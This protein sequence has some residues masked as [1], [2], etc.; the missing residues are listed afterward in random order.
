MIKLDNLDEIVRF[1]H[2]ITDNG[3][4]LKELNYYS[5]FDG[6]LQKYLDKLLNSQILKSSP[7]KAH[8][9]LNHNTSSEESVFKCLNSASSKSLKHKKHSDPPSPSPS[10]FLNSSHPKQKSAKKTEMHSKLKKSLIKTEEFSPFVSKSSSRSD[11]TQR[12]T[13]KE[14]NNEKSG[15]GR[16]E[17]NRDSE[18]QRSRERERESLWPILDRSYDEEKIILEGS[19]SREAS[20][21][22]DYK[23]KNQF[24]Q[25]RNKNRTINHQEFH[26]NMAENVQMNNI[27]LNSNLQHKKQGTPVFTAKPEDDQ[28][29]PNTSISRTS[30]VLG[31]FLFKLFNLHHYLIGQFSPAPSTDPKGTKTITTHQLPCQSNAMVIFN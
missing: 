17:R 11:S 21:N 22:M 31:I 25:I 9:P 30:S 16:S 20:E 23:N 27:N 18:K 26:M 4:N 28:K 3:K 13:G 24:N 8:S 6:A 5:S 15:N 14:K 2:R 10:S 29:P 1:L 19:I 12:R 7:L